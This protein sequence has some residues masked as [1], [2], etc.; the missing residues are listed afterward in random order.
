[1]TESSHESRIRGRT[2]ALDFIAV[3]IEKWE[4]DAEKTACDD[5]TADVFRQCSEELESKIEDFANT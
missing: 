2:E 1:M 4:K 3:L 5:V